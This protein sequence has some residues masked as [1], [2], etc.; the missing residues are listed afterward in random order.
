MGFLV[1]SLYSKAKTTW[2]TDRL[3]YQD[4]LIVIKHQLCEGLVGW[5]F[6]LMAVVKDSGKGSRGG[7]RCE[8]PAEG[9]VNVVSCVKPVKVNKRLCKLSDKKLTRAHVNFVKR[10]SRPVNFFQQKVRVSTMSWLC[11]PLIQAILK[12][13]N[14]EQKR[15]KVHTSCVVQCLHCT[16]SDG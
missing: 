14:R 1:T 3:N 6:N 9:A 12:N 10:S 16:L 4:M 11:L 8:A 13:L 15:S 2:H 7:P 5:N